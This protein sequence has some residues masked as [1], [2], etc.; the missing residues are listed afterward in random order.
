MGNF[1]LHTY[2]QIFCN[3][4]KK[5]IICASLISSV[6]SLFQRRGPHDYIANSV[7]LRFSLGSLELLIIR[8]QLDN[9]L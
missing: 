2:E 8:Y 4:I 6:V 1:V 3:I 5:F 9:V 7:I